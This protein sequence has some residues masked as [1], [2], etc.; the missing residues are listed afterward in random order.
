[1][2]TWVQIGKELGIPP[3]TAYSICRRALKKLRSRPRQL[4]RLKKLAAA[5]EAARQRRTKEG[6]QCS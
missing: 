1:V 6:A 5:L 3:Q 4:E 2:K